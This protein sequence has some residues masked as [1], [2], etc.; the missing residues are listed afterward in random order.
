MAIGDA[1]S[2]SIRIKEEALSVAKEEVSS[3]TVKALSMES[4]RYDELKSL[5]CFEMV[6][7]R[8]VHGHSITDVAR[9]IIDESG[10]TGKMTKVKSFEGL[11][12]LLT[13]FRKTLKS[14][15][16]VSKLIPE[17]VEEARK[18]LEDGIDE[19][20][21]LEYLYLIQKDRIEI[22]YTTEKKIK[23]LFKNTGNEVAIAMGVL[24][25]MFNLKQDLGLLKRDLGRIE[26]DHT[27]MTELPYKSKAIEE[28]MRNPASRTKVMGMVRRL[29][30]K[31]DLVDEIL[32]SASSA[33]EIVDAE[34]E[35]IEKKDGEVN[36]D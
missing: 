21:E 26:V 35:T 19:I 32:S 13:D 34:V 30:T 1:V 24:K 12:D 4:R 8:L 36:A 20:K 16:L 5:D 11:R 23:K 33:R 22:D 7:S 6:K 18:K 10:E 9:F 25:L 2:G 14:S 15:E 27:M 3:D 17:A 29:L 28:V 31:P